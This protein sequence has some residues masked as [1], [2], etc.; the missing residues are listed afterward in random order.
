MKK[1]YF[2]AIILCCS[3]QANAQ[4]SIH[5]DGINDFISVSNASSL[6]SNSNLSISFWVYPT[7]PSPNYPN[8]DGFAGFRNNTNADFYILHLSTT[9][10]EARFRNS[11]GTNYDIVFS[12][13]VPSAWNHFAMTY[14]G[15]TLTLYHNGVSV[16]TQ[17]ASGNITSS[18]EPFYIGNL[19][20]QT[21]NF[22]LNGQMDDVT[23]WSKSLSASEVSAIYNACSMDLTASGLELCYEFNQGTAGGNNSTMTT[24]LDSKGNI[25]GVLNNFA[26]NGATSNFVAYSK[27]AFSSITTSVCDGTYT[28][29]KGN[30]LS[31]TGTYYD[32]LVAGSVSGCDSIIGIYLTVGNSTNNTVIAPSK[33]STYTSPSGNYTWTTSGTYSDTIPSVAGCDSVI[34]INLSINNSSLSFSAT[35][36]DRYISPSGIHTWTVSSTYTDVINNYL[37]CDSTITVNLTINPSPD[38]SVT[39]NTNTLTATAT[40]AS[41][42]WLDCDNGYAAVTGA[43]GQ[44]F[45]ATANGNY[46]VEVELNGCID[47]SS[48][49]SVFQVSTFNPFEDNI[50]IYPNPTKSSFWIDL[51]KSYSDVSIQIMDITGKVVSS[52]NFNNFEKMEIG[53]NVP[54][55]VYF[56]AIRSA[57]QRK[58]SKILIE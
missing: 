21:T 32:T 48:C 27:N 30:V 29:P 42:R 57:Q 33:C 11:S 25:N 3:F 22:Y 50:Q 34:T 14:N 47:T 7:N 37:G 16:G 12:S 5:F 46:A 24:V 58:V 51:G 18:A 43:T 39:Q 45:V 15:S 40:G 6:I 31:A 52:E 10:V 49:Y 55:G 19:P 53:L 23:L 41:Y 56:V 44:T 2:L 35:A 38:T 17:S 28:S 9:S 36:C 13:L 20:F 26:M 1:F 4:N 54:K 8:F